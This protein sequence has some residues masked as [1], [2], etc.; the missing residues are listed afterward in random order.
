MRLSLYIWSSRI[1]PKWEAQRERASKSLLDRH[2]QRTAVT[3]GD[4][5]HIA[6]SD[7]AARNPVSDV[8][9]ALEALEDAVQ[10]PA[11]DSQAMCAV[12]KFGTV[13]QLPGYIRAASRPG[14]HD[15]QHGRALEL[16]APASGRG[17]LPQALMWPRLVVMR[18]EL[19]HD[20]GQVM[21][22]EDQDVI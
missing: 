1:E 19:G 20:M 15:G 16:A 9:P 21:A 22:T 7:A 8:Q 13:T 18:D 3:V 17:S 10:I 6:E 12:N 4:L 2:A 5:L 11:A 14:D